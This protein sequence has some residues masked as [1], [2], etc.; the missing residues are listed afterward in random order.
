[1]VAPAGIAKPKLVACTSLEHQPAAKAQVT[2][3]LL[4][5]VA[6][7]RPTH[8]AA[9]PKSVNSPADMVNDCWYAFNGNKKN[10]RKNNL[11]IFIF[12]GLS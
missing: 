4:L 6:L 7:P 10:A 3:T 8:G 12:I 1:M 5:Y 9:P 11:I 2:Y